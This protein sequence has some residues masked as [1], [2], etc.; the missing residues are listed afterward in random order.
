[1]YPESLSFIVRDTLTYGASTTPFYYPPTSQGS[2]FW[3]ILV[4]SRLFLTPGN[5]PLPRGPTPPPRVPSLFIDFSWKDL[6]WNSVDFGDFPLLSNT[7]HLGRC[8][9]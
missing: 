6:A 3:L 9:L 4:T 1:M 7:F 8:H 5:G 2:S